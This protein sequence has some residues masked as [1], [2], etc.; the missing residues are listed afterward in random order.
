M[1]C[2]CSTLMKLMIVTAV[3]TALVLP[4]CSSD[5]EKAGA[6]KI[7]PKNDA[8]VTLSNDATVS[9]DTIY[10]E[11]KYQMSDIPFDLNGAPV[12]VAGVT[13]TPASQ[14]KDLGG[15]GSNVAHYLYGPLES[16]TDSAVVKVFY[17][18]KDA[19]GTWEENF[20][21]WINQIELSGG[22]DPHQAALT[23]DRIVDGMTAH[24]LSMYGT[25]LA[26]S[27]GPMSGKTIPKDNYRMV[28]IVLEAPEGNVFFKLTGPDYT[29][30]IMIEA[31][32]NMIYVVKKTA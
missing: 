21:R 30:R 6:G 29:A 23:H 12:K 17:F 19:G 26:S 9:G 22:R 5:K 11:I 4:A 27:G 15:E 20:E 18:G 2:R 7:A 16:D 32:M 24:V 31:F 13:F 3:L 10:K 8:S 28:G 14:W 1:I 25:Y